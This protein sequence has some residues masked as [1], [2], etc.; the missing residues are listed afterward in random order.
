MS[1]SV[2]SKKSRLNQIEASACPVLRATFALSAR[3]SAAPISGQTNRRFR[4]IRAPNAGRAAT[5]ARVTPPM[6]RCRVSNGSSRSPAS[7]ARSAVAC[8]RCARSLM[9]QRWRSG[10][11]CARSHPF[12]SLAHP[13]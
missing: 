6:A 10:L 13:G 5:T 9:A 8:I 3:R 4:S 7:N 1:P 12:P 2:V 11:P